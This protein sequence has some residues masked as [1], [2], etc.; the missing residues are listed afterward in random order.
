M[1]YITCNGTKLYYEEQGNGTETIV[2]SHGLLLNHSMFSAQI[3]ALKNR[4][5]IIAYDHR[6]QGKSKFA[7]TG[8]D[9]NTL[10]EDVADLIEKLSPNKP[11]HF[12]GLS[13]GG[14]V[15][16]R[17]AARKP[18]LLRSLALLNT[19]ASAEPAPARRKYGLLT[20]LVKIFGVK[21]VHNKVIE[22][23][24]GKTFLQDP[25]RQAIRSHWEA[26]LLALPKKI[27]QPVEGVFRRPAIKAELPYI[28][29]PVLIIA[30]AEDVATPAKLSKKIQQ[31]IPHAHLIVL[32]QVGHSSTIEAPETVSQCLI[33]FLEKIKQYNI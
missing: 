32:D 28:T 9:M 15:G 5:R 2:F 3:D 30:G 17:L 26:Q 16:M 7:P 14:F 24:F 1:P 6:G 13:M 33:D 10:Y 21:S 19:S 18:N 8:Y 11:V 23:M 27:I 12:V 25:S 4:Y 22:I 31:A 20:L 29:C